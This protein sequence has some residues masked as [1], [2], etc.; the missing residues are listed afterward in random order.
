MHRQGMSYRKIGD[1]LGVSDSAIYLACNE[2]AYRRS[3]ERVRAWIYAGTCPDC[4][5]PATRAGGQSRCRKCAF[6][7]LSTVR[8]GSAKCSTCNEWKP[9]SEFTKSTNAFRKVRGECRA[10]GTIRRREW[11]AKNRD[12]ENMVARARKAVG[13]AVRRGE[14]TRPTVCPVCNSSE[15]RIEAHHEDYSKPLE[16]SWL[17]SRC[18]TAVRYG[19]L[20][21]PIGMVI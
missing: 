9:L 3:R 7:R 21:L 10:C 1:A 5:T 2:A 15:N 19:K 17:C 13:S 20:S 11:R 4:G 16:V 6:E 12:Y 8:D 18:H 14:L